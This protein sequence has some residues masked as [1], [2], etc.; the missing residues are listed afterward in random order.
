MRLKSYLGAGFDFDGYNGCYEEG[1]KMKEYA[2][3]IKWLESEPHY[4]LKAMCEADYQAGMWK[5][6][7]AAKRAAQ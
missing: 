2:E 4:E 5:A 1:I 3:F 7:Q 6:W